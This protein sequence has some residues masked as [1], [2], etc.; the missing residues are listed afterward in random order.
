MSHAL[1]KYLLGVFNPS[2]KYTIDNEE[3]KSY[4]RVNKLTFD[5]ATKKATLFW[6]DSPVCEYDLAPYVPSDDGVLTVLL[7]NESKIAISLE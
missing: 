5:M 2:L 7:S 4:I 6:N 1:K 3:G